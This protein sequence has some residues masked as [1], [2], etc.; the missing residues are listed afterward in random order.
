MNDAQREIGPDQL[1]QLEA[2]ILTLRPV[3]REIFLLNRVEK[4]SY[5]E[6]SGRLDITT[7]QVERTIAAAICALDREICRVNRPRCRLW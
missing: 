2:A 3:H 1:Q 4:L 6:I 5:A 7:E